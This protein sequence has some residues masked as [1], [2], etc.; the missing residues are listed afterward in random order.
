MCL[1]LTY[2]TEGGLV[3]HAITARYDCNEKLR[4]CHTGTR[5]ELLSMIR[6]WVEYGDAGSPRT[7]ASG[8]K[9]QTA[10][11]FWINGP[12]SA[13]TG[14]STIAY[15]VARDLDAQKKLGASFFCSRGKADCS[16]PKLIFPTIAYQLG[17]FY[18]PFREQVSAVL[19]ADPDVA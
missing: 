5:T 12:G 17:Q 13:G 9:L 15:T 7:D 6:C 2:L 14:K 18:A 11:V 4:P 8:D 1:I 16:N 3:P 10:R 19:E